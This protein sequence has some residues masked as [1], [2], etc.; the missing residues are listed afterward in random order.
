MNVFGQGSPGYLEQKYLTEN[1]HMVDSDTQAPW[2]LRKLAG[3][4]KVHY[5]RNLTNLKGRKD[6]RYQ[7]LKL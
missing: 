4:W 7:H 5:L 3:N 1:D 6:P 2:N